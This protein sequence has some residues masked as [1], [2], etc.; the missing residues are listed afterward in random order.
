MILDD[1]DYNDQVKRLTFNNST[2]QKA[3]EATA[4]I[5]LSFIHAANGYQKLSSVINNINVYFLSKLNITVTFWWHGL[6]EKL[7]NAPTCR[8][9]DQYALITLEKGTSFCNYVIHILIS[10][11]CSQFKW[12]KVNLYKM[13]WT[14]AYELISNGIYFLKQM[15]FENIMKLFK[16]F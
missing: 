8:R 4:L 2:T 9:Y 16:V 13:V 14:V 5:L 3:H 11:N 1:V 7:W 10:T 15:K 6:N 12:F